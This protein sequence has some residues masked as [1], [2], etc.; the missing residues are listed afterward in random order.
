MAAILSAILV[1]VC[2]TK[3]IFELEPW[4][5]GIN[6]YMKFGRNSIKNDLERVTTTADGCKLIHG[7]HFIGNLDYGLSDTTHIQT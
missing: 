2:L 1:I 5:D 4:F 3:L 6:L 7:G